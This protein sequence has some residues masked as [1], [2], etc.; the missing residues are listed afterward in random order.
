MAK[1]AVSIT[2]VQAISKRLGELVIAWAREEH[3]GQLLYILELQPEQRGKL[4]GCVCI[5]CA[6]P[7]TA[8]NAA[9]TEWTVRPHFRH[10]AGTES[11]SCGVLS[12]RAALIAA[13]HEG[14]MI[15]LPMSRRSVEFLGLSG[16]VY[17]TWIELPREKVQI[18]EVHFSDNVT[19]AIVLSDGRRLEVQVTG[20]T[21]QDADG[22][23]TP[24]IIITVDDPNLATMSPDEL[25]ARLVPMIE[26]GQWCGHWPQPELDAQKL[27]DAKRLAIESLDWDNS[28]TSMQ[29]AD[30]R[31]SLLHKEV[32][33]ILDEAR[34][35]TIPG[36][37]LNVVSQKGQVFRH[38]E[39]FKRV[40]LK[41]TVLEHR[42]GRIVPD[43]VAT[44]PNDSELLIEVTVTNHI[45]D[46]RLERI[47]Q[48]NLPTLEIDFSH[49]GGIVN[50]ERLR[51]LV[52]DEATGKRWLHHPLMNQH[53][54]GL[55]YRA[56]PVPVDQDLFEPTIRD[57]RLRTPQEWA[58]QYLKAVC[59]HAAVRWTE[60]TGSEAEDHQERVREALA[61]V[62]IA[63]GA[64]RVYGHRI[65]LDT[66]LYD[67]GHTVLERL[68]SIQQD[69][70]IGYLYDNGWQ[71]VN[72]MM[73]DN[74]DSAKSWHTL[75]LIAIST[76]KP[77]MT[78]KQQTKYQS[79]RSEVIASVN[80]GEVTYLRNT[81]FDDLFKLLF[82]EMADSLVKPFGKRP[83]AMATQSSGA[84]KKPLSIFP[85]EAFQRDDLS[86]IW[87]VS[88][89]ERVQRAEDES[90]RARHAGVD[91]KEN[92]ILFHLLR[93]H[94]AEQPSRYAARI[95][96]QISIT[97]AEIL[98]YLHSEGYIKQSGTHE[99]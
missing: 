41:S 86:W 40:A 55:H 33:A 89:D 44:L 4:C 25:R 49:M 26:A 10:H 17:E 74:G 8:V 87:A 38:R 47:K 84:P 20:T 48:V 18:K 28:P 5:S 46:E 13:L 83:Q 64:L 6:S 78:P 98:R 50:R 67:H 21:D 2:K 43:V 7:L 66:R 77:K 68:L 79:W 65:A 45:T 29:A 39:P 9:K 76:Y 22:G 35:L 52:L 82:P 90:V 37:D 99:S 88:A 15:V 60:V 92:G 11:H 96:R 19:A 56:R 81:Q 85:I 31:E 59:E 75:Y 93:S 36:W 53:L 57:I 16:K 69:K 97:Q 34:S 71:V 42:L 27:E 14:D 70:G 12:A 63:G 23:I 51:R 58:Q 91:V 24:R 95:A 54:A 30:R 73:T 80:R 1:T 94:H 72:T 62:E 32:K 3:T 61:A